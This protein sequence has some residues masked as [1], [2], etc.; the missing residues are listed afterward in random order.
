LNESPVVQPQVNS[1]S[2]SPARRSRA[3]YVY[4]ILGEKTNRVKIGHAADPWKRI[5]DLQVGSPDKLS[6][7]L[8]TSY[9]VDVLSG[10]RPRILAR[11]DKR[12]FPRRVG[13]YPYRQHKGRKLVLADRTE[14]PVKV[15]AHELRLMHQQ[16]GY[17]VHSSPPWAR[18]RTHGAAIQK[19][20]GVR[21]SHTI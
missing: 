3:G 13:L 19:C 14:A 21:D 20:T 7:L 15:M 8:V 17:A 9:A 6:M 12:Q 18:S 5:K 4:F 11:I 10:S 16:H 1:P 2:N